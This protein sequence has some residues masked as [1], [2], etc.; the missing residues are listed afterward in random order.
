MALE[1][2]YMLH[3]NLRRFCSGESNVCTNGKQD[4]YMVYTLEQNMLM[5]MEY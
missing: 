1:L 4:F 3:F 2:L 5:Y